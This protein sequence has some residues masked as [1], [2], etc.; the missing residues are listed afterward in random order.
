MTDTIHVGDRIIR[1]PFVYKKQK[2]LQY[3]HNIKSTKT[4]QW[5]RPT[6][7]KLNEW[8]LQ[9]TRWKAMGF[10]NWTAAPD[11]SPRAVWKPPSQK[12]PRCSV[13]RIS[14]SRRGKCCSLQWTGS[15]S[16]SAHGPRCSPDS[17]RPQTL[18]RRR[19][20]RRPHPAGTMSSRVNT[21]TTTANTKVHC[22]VEDAIRIKN[23]FLFVFSQSL[24]KTVSLFRRQ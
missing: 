17:A 6:R 24:L 22:N 23:T 2:H 7:F 12:L 20:A 18:D 21:S 13:A 11:T 4:S 15:P 19:N 3:F 1:I 9:L 14:R 10:K 5:K 16:A 8:K